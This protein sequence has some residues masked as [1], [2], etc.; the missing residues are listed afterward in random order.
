M[1]KACGKKEKK[2]RCKN[3]VH[4]ILVYQ[5]CFCSLPEMPLDEGNM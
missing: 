5:K 3:A 4:Y 2:K 1:P